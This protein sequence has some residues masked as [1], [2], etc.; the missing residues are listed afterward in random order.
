MV[1]NVYKYTFV[2]RKFKN[3]FKKIVK[4]FKMIFVLKNVLL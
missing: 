1:S 2:T 3:C 4:I